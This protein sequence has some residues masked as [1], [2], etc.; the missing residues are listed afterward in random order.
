MKRFTAEMSD[1]MRCSSSTRTDRPILVAVTERGGRQT[2]NHL[3]RRM[4]RVPR[5][6]S[7]S[8]NSSASKSHRAKGKRLT[9][10]EVATLR[11]IEP[12]LPPEPE[13]SD[14]GD[15]GEIPR[16]PALRRRADDGR[17]MPV[18]ATPRCFR[19]VEFEIER[20]RAMP[21]RVIDP[22]TTEPVLTCRR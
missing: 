19:R 15:A 11:F 9:T 8:T 7:T 12:E 4:R 10:Y 1:K 17:R 22:R 14:D 16:R 20:A 3:R 5:T 2:R 6:R 18:P 21:T 13:P